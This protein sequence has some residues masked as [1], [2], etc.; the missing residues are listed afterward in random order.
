[1][2]GTVGDD[3][4]ALSNVDVGTWMH[5]F[6]IGGDINVS[7]TFFLTTLHASISLSFIFLL[8]FFGAMLSLLLEYG[9]LF[10]TLFTL[11]FSHE[12][13]NGQKIKCNT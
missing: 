13:E 3:T 9:S 4:S 10:F 11:T 8:F 6:I 7:P 12:R 2:C 1:M 5:N